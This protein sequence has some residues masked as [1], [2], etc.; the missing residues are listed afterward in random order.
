MRK[1]TGISL[2]L[3][4]FLSLCLITF[5][6]LSFSGATADQ[7]L[8]QKAADHTTEYYQ[9]VSR[10]NEVLNFV[11]AQ[12]KILIADV[13]IT[14][15]TASL[16]S[17]ATDSC[18]GTDNLETNQN[19]I[20]EPEQLWFKICEAIHMDSGFADTLSTNFTDLSFVFEEK[21]GIPVLSFEVSTT[22]T[23]G[24][25]LRVTLE[26]SQPETETDPLYH[27]TCWQIVNT[28][29]WTPDYSQNLMRM[30]ELSD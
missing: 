12:L 14:N 24:Q 16:D 23:S 1:T 30:T 4:I 8:S 13:T 28:S 27:I 17:S 29:D 3:L 5:S 15:Q 18:I 19:A 26:F 7:R 2:L 22:E 9:M 21:D 25:V 6:L 10:A 20:F 11:D